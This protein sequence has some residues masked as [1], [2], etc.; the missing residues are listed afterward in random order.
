[1][2]FQP[3]IVNESLHKGE[4]GELICHASRNVIVYH[5]S[6]DLAL[7]ASKASN[8]KNKIASRRLGHTGPE[9]M[10]LTPA[11]VYTVDCDD[12]NNAYDPPKGHS[13][14]RSGKTKGE[15]GK[16][17]SHIFAIMENGRVFPEDQFK[18][19]TIIK[20]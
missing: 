10:R 14:F 16:V 20:D 4:I 17:F 2:V 11:N 8:L 7:R 18:R 12:I 19:A 13:Y 1:M 3:D 15:P 9:N 5:A 6:D